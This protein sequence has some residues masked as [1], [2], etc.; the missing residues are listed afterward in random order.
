MEFPKFQTGIFV[1]WK[2]STKVSAGKKLHKR[3]KER[4]QKYFQNIEKLSPIK[5]KERYHK[6]FKSDFKERL[7][8]NQNLPLYFV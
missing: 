1:E 4:V 2:A 8:V 6:I 7:M 3:A 5:N